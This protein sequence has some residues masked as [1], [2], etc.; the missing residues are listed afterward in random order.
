MDQQK[1]IVDTSIWIEY[2]RNNE[3][4]VPL[5]EKNLSLENIL[6]TGLII[7]ELLH[8]VKGSREYEMLSGSI[9]AVP[10]VECVYEDWIKTGKILNDLKKKGISIPL[11]DVL[12]AAVAHREN[13]AVFTLDRHFKDILVVTTLDLYQDK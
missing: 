4:Y 9:A 5:I 1:I 11:T 3:K 2:F 13:A 12:I 10:Y 7:A 8:G 6:I